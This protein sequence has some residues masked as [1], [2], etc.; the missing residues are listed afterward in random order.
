MASSIYK[1]KVSWDKFLP[2]QIYIG[3]LFVSSLLFPYII[4][5]ALGS[6]IFDFYPKYRL[7][8]NKRQDILKGSS[9]Y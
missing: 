9:G 2:C 5:T 8:I 6:K 1:D 7:S 3:V 4:N